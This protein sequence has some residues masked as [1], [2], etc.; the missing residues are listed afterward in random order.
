MK[1]GEARLRVNNIKI[2]GKRVRQYVYM[3]K[4]DKRWCKEQAQLKGISISKLLGD[5][6]QKEIDDDIRLDLEY[7]DAE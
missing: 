1:K 6:V 7:G 4:E 2:E 3:S 5:M